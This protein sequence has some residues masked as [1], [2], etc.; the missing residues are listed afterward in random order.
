MGSGL[1]CTK[2]VE[3]QRPDG[4]LDF[5]AQGPCVPPWKIACGSEPANGLR[6]G[7]WEWQDGLRWHELPDFTWPL[8]ERAR[9]AGELVTI[10]LRPRKYSELDCRCDTARTSALRILRTPAG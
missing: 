2:P 6:I 9:R 7:I 8:L 1:D 10:E 4:E 3:D 5:E